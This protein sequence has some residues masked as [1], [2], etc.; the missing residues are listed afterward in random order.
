MSLWLAWRCSYGGGVRPC[1]GNWSLTIAPLPPKGDSVTV[2]L[3]QFDA[4][5]DTLPGTSVIGTYQLLGG[6]GLANQNNLDFLGSQN[7]TVTI[8]PVPEPADDLLAGIGL[9]LLT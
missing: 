9:I 3:F 5:A 7:F 2:A 4:P 8:A 1:A 6:V